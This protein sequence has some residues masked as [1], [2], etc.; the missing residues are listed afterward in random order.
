MK[1]TLGRF[2]KIF[3]AIITVSQ[4]NIM[5]PTSCCILKS[6]GYFPLIIQ[7]IIYYFSIIN[8][9]TIKRGKKELSLWRRETTLISFSLTS[10]SKI[11]E[12]IALP[13]NLRLLNFF[14]PAKMTEESKF[15][16]GLRVRWANRKRYRSVSDPVHRA[17]E[18]FSLLQAT[19]GG[20]PNFFL[21]L[22]M[23]AKN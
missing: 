23:M 22:G 18:V 19:A 9:R 13:Q 20:S 7:W 14:V 4:V 11:L 8:S 16:F 6:S 10:G 15:L 2:W 1:L 5:Q 3:W 12:E 17:K 21:R